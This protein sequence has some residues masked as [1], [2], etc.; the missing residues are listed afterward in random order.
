[1]PPRLPAGTRR[2]K[3]RLLK[4]RPSL[5]ARLVILFARVTRQKRVFTDLD[6]LQKS[7]EE[8]QVPE[9]RAI[10][11][12]V[13]RTCDVE[14]SEVG[15]WPVFRV[16]SRQTTGDR[17]TI[18]YLHGGGYVHEIMRLHWKLVVR[19]ADEFDCSV[20]VPL[21]PLAPA[22]TYREVFPT[23]LQIYE[24]VTRRGEVILM[25]DSA[26]GGMALALLLLAKERGLPQPRHVVAFSPWLDV[27]MSNPAIREL[28]KIDPFLAAPGNIACGEM[29]AGGD[30]RTNPLISPIYG[31]LRGVSSE[32][33]IFIGTRE[34]L[35]PD[36]R[37]FRDLATAAG[38]RLN[39]REYD[40]MF[41]V[42]L[43]LPYLRESKRAFEELHRILG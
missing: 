26:G 5:L 2:S 3:V 1:M 17:R 42:W 15:R 31:D 41:H 39:Y 23:L 6:R 16:R 25:G 10:A 34:L 9:R 29:Y 28:E 33:T 14:E 40:G 18:L 35:L 22:A 43:A 38:V 19:L 24:E 12:F 21:Y 7:I 27:T 36:A 20:V 11:D 30:D 37:R 8:S 32:V 4:M 13:R